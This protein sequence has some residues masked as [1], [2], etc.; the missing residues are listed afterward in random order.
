MKILKKFPDTLSLIVLILL[1]VALL[2]WILP[3]GEFERE[4]IGTKSQVI[5]GTYKTVESNP[6]LLSVFTA[7]IKGF[8][9]QA[10]VI[11]FIFLIGGAFFIINATGSINSALFKLLQLTSKK[12]FLERFVI[13]IIMTLFSLG[14]A[15]FGMAEETLVFIMI[16]IPLA[17]ALG[18]DSIVGLSMAFIGAAVG[19]AGAFFNPFTVGI[20]QGI[21]GL[22]PFSGLGYRLIVW[23]V[24]TAVGIIYVSLYA[25]KVKRRTVKEDTNVKAI[26]EIPFTGKRLT[27]LFLLAF[28]II[29]LA[30]GVQQDNPEQL[31]QM[32]EWLRDIRI[33]FISLGI[34]D[35]YIIEI[36]GLFVAL[37][38]VSG[39]I[40]GFKIS[41]IID[42]FWNGAK[43][44]LIPALLIA[45]A[46]GILVIAED[47]KIIDTI[48]YYVSDAASDLSP[49]I[50]AQIML[51][52]QGFIN[53]F[54][55]SGSGQ[56]AL[57][58]PIMAPLAD[59][60]GVT[61]QT[62]VLAYQFGDGI[63]NMIIPTSAV[64]MGVLEIGKIDYKRWFK[65]ILPLVI[66]LYLIS[67]VLLAVAVS[68]NWQ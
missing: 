50:S 16:T 19:F 6:Q 56:A 12:P 61:R 42:H 1:F 13:P 38:F 24:Y 36:A 30:I 20:A 67:M 4:V 35:W 28:T 2:T 54:V 11:A 37:G 66:I 14:G 64:L 40:Y 58:M 41:E 3:S 15:T 48:L 25:R 44:M 34:N 43:E 46:R 57:T 33:N 27:I 45:F 10:E 21:A 5:P 52:V 59:V 17:I 7:P 63:T 23:L 18:Y 53:T 55:P 31:A 65:F 47:G 29:L 51:F 9:H 22:P 68:I 32:P 49:M 26:E 8:I 60:L 62:A 39:I